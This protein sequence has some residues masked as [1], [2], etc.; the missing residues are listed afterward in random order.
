MK[1]KLNINVL[2]PAIAITVAAVSCTK[3]ERIPAADQEIAFTVGTYAPTKVSDVYTTDEIT[4]FTSKAFLHANGAAAGTDYFGAS[5]TTINRTTSGAGVTWEPSRTY[6][7][8]IA[9]ATYLN[10]VSWFDNGGA[11]TTATET[12]LEWNS[13]SIATTDNILYADEAWNFHGNLDTYYTSGVPT[14]FHHALA[15]I[16]FTAK[17]SPL[18]DPEHAGTTWTVTI[19]SASISALHTA[20]TMRLTNSAPSTGTAQT[21]AWNCA[22]ELLW[23]ATD[24][25]H[26]VSLGSSLALTGTA[27]DLYAMSS[28]LPQNLGNDVVLTLEYTVA[29]YSNNVLTATETATRHIQ[30]NRLLNTSDIYITKWEPN[31]K[32]T[33]NI[34]INPMIG[35]IYL[36]P[37]VADWNTASAYATVE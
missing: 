32:Y 1:H 6:Y 30:L 37:A 14:L 23:S 27:Q 2:L 19:N 24:A 15:R 22:Q 25:A 4:S 13:R 8:P 11:P 7:W 26:S 3:V 28:V 5:G 33:Y 29:T 9:Q 17:A 10:F 31:K 18:T 36:N 21:K 16:A 20:G 34:T 12:V 35:Q